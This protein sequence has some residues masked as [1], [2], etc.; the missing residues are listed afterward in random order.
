[1][2]DIE[3]KMVL[4]KTVKHWIYKAKKV[5]A[6]DF[7]Q[8]MNDYPRIPERISRQNLETI[9]SYEGEF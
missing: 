3:R 6:T 7:R 5:K 1:M 8:A 9:D 2:K 4:D